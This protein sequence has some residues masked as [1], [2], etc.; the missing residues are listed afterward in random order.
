MT[1]HLPECGKPAP[2]RAGCIC[3]RLRANEM[4]IRSEYDEYKAMLGGIEYGAERSWDYA[5]DAAREAVAAVENDPD[6]EIDYDRDY[7][8]DPTGNTRNPRMWLHDAL[9][10]IDA[11]RGE[12]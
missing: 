2:F 10:A 3:D 8:S 11:L 7:R 5:L 6:A 9:R 1:E 12:R 4:R